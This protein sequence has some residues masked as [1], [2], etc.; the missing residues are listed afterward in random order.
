[1]WW[2]W[3]IWTDAAV[4][5]LFLMLE[6]HT[7]LL[8][9]VAMQ[10]VCATQCVLSL[11]T[12]KTLY[13][14]DDY[15]QDKQRRERSR[16]ML[17]KALKAI[18]LSK[19]QQRDMCR[20]FDAMPLFLDPVVHS[21][22]TYELLATIYDVCRGS[23]IK[24]DRNNINNNNNTPES[25]ALEWTESR[26]LHWFNLLETTTQ[27]ELLNL[28][29]QCMLHMRTASFYSELDKTSAEA[30]QARMV[31]KQAKHMRFLRKAL[32]LKIAESNNNNNTPSTTHQQQQQHVAD[33][34]RP[35]PSPI[36]T[37]KATNDE[38]K[39]TVFGDVYSATRFEHA[40][41]QHLHSVRRL[42][43]AL[44]ATAASKISMLTPTTTTS[45]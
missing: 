42:H 31:R 17:F 3:L 25:T 36:T 9:N 30:M 27:Q 26:F 29:R 11:S 2:E 32:L 5:F 24:S 43:A 45:S 35:E 8:K 13:S 44:L 21:E 37:T 4:V 16:F 7:A 18:G 28:A 33:T 12:K 34:R 15:M 6:M 19:H 41:N 1:M 40:H 10:T 14:V 20:V 22:N 23:S 38:N 39:K